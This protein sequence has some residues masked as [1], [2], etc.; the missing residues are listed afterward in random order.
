MNIHSSLGLQPEHSGYGVKYYYKNNH[1]NIY[2]NRLKCIVMP[3]LFWFAAHK[4]CKVELA[5]GKLLTNSGFFGIFY[6]L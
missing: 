2:I 1:T 3:I 6:S 5:L 4:L